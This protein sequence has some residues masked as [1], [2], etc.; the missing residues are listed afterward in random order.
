MKKCV[1][2]FAVA[3]L[4]VLN[5]P[6]TIGFMVRQHG[7][8][9]L[10]GLKPV[11]SATRLNSSDTVTATATPQGAVGH[12]VAT[13]KFSSAGEWNWKVNAF[14]MD[15][16]M[17]ALAVQSAPSGKSVTSTTAYA[18]SPFSIPLATVL[19]GLIVALGALAV[20]LRARKPWA[21]A[22]AVA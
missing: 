4:L 8:S 12:Y 18:P 21:V 15:Q 16:P 5:E 11:I 13:L 1:F 22:V 3:T 7:R 17:P 9:P 20:W 6:V 14:G 10:D 2:A 19:T